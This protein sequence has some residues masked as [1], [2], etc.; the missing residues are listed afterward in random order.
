MKYIDEVLF[1]Y[2]WHDANTIKNSDKMRQFALKTRENEINILKNLDYS[3]V[4]DGVEKTFLK[5]AIQKKQGIPFLFEVR[6]VV[7]ERAK[8]RQFFFLG[9]MFQER[10]VRDL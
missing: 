4:L 7:K 5:G 10:K 8:F 9:K 6:T 3:K 2:R 1:S